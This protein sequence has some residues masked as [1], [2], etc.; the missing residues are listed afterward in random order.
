MTRFRGNIEGEVVL[1]LNEGAKAKPSFSAARKLEA[2]GRR[3]KVKHGDSHPVLA[4]WDGDGKPDLIVGTGAGGVMFYRNTGTREAPNFAAGEALIIEC[5]DSAPAV[6]QTHE[7]VGRRAKI[8]VCDYDDDGRLDLLVGDFSMTSGETSRPSEALEKLK[9]EAEERFL[10]IL[11]K[12]K[13]V[14]DELREATTVPAEESPDA[15][16]AR[17]KKLKALQAKVQEVF[18]E[19]RPY[20]EVVGMC[21]MNSECH[22]SVWLFQ[23]RRSTSRLNAQVVDE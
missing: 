10:Q 23:R 18:E 19:G 13:R 3:I 17:E 14:F 15:K 20:R 6:G 2:N 11:R 16:A 4:D 1:Y 12:H 8:C 21:Q 7:G 5:P 9:H 22:G